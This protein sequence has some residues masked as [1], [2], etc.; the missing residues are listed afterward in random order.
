MKK[1]LILIFALV[2]VFL[3]AVSAFAESGNHVFT[4]DPDTG[5]ISGEVNA[6]GNVEI[7][8]DGALAGGSRLS[9]EVEDGVHTVETFV[10]G[11]SILTETVYVNVPEGY[12]EPEEEEPGETAEPAVT[13]AEPTPEAAGSGTG[14]FNLTREQ[15]L[16]IIIALTAVVVILIAVILVK[17]FKQS[18]KH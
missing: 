8:L 7:W 12:V 13:A 6:N 5:R 2:L 1:R 14:L 17:V 10:D 3:M 15:L 11:V 4:Y 18:G 16:P 9:V